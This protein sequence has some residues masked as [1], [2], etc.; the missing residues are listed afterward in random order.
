MGQQQILILILVTIIVALAIVLGLQFI[1]HEKLVLEES[2]MK[3]ELLEIASEAQAYYRKEKM[4]GGGGKSFMGITFKTI[5]C[6]LDKLENGDVKCVTETGNESYVLLP[7]QES[8]GVLSV[9]HNESQHL[10]AIFEIT[11][12]SVGWRIEW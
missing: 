5:P 4:L 7:K 12:D 1:K 6:P 3:Q 2:R 8:L 11:P 10:T 9:I